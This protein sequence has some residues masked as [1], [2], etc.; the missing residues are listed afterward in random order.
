M[1]T[2]TAGTFTEG[3]EGGIVPPVNWTSI[4]NDGD[5]WNW[6]IGNTFHTGA[7][8]AW[9]YSWDI[10]E[11]VLLT[12]DDWLITPQM[13]IFSHES[14]LTYW[15]TAADPV[16]PTQ[17]FEVWVST[18]GNEVANFTD[19]VDSH[20]TTDANWHQRSVDLSSFHSQNIYV[21]FRHFDD[22]GLGYILMLDDITITGSYDPRV[23]DEG[24][25]ST[26]ILYI[27]TFEDDVIGQ[28]PTSDWY[29]Y[30]ET[31]D[32]GNITDDIYHKSNKSFNF[33]QSQY[34]FSWFNLTTYD[35]YSYFEYWF[36]S[37]DNNGQN[38]T[39]GVVVGNLTSVTSPYP[40]D[41]S[42]IITRMRFGDGSE[43]DNMMYQYGDDQYGYFDQ[44]MLFNNWYKIRV[45]FNWTDHTMILS[46]YNGIDVE[47]TSW[48][49]QRYDD[50]T[51]D[52]ISN[53]VIHAVNSYPFTLPNAY[54][55][56]MTLGNGHKI[57]SL[58]IT[59][60]KNVP[61]VI[62]IA[63]AVNSVVGI[64]LIIF[65]I[66]GIITIVSKFGQ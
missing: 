35:N 23:N 8:S 32:V 45:T 66:M 61:D 41:S 64:I 52:G 38:G 50:G 59:A 58:R 40:H 17:H 54:I 39:F 10:G 13:S 15:V 62:E 65:A 43:D 21:A 34:N 7:H 30:W 31:A 3:F 27:E 26:D 36:Y 11:G 18:S 5:G 2:V 48:L 4:D 55:D 24:W 63:D 28:N 60:R 12:P 44:C 46:L 51:Q 29:T 19:M 14:Q 25:N 16:W 20:T 57:T 6:Q 22:A 33:T 56:N 9:S 42:D 47:N 1:H 49:D 37:R 53:I